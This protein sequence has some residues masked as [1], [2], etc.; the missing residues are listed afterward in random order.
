VA[1]DAV[2]NELLSDLQEGSL[3]H[4]VVYRRDFWRRRFTSCCRS[5]TGAQPSG[6][7]RLKSSGARAVI[8]ASIPARGSVGEETFPPSPSLA[9]LLDFG[10]PDLD[11]RRFHTGDSGHLC[12]GDSA[13]DENGDSLLE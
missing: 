8:C 12:D 6:R 9:I 5:L 13:F 1:D 4:A 11:S 7:D 2:W 10:S 3:C